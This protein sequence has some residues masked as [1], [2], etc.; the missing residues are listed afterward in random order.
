MDAAIGID[1][2][3]VEPVAA[4]FTA[5]DEPSA[6]L[7]CSADVCADIADKVM[8]DT[9]AFPGIA[10]LDAI[11]ATFLDDTVRDL[12][13]VK[14]RSGIGL[15]RAVP[16][17]KGFGGDVVKVAV[18]NVGVVLNPTS[19]DIGEEAADASAGSVRRIRVVYFEVIEFDLFDLSIDAHSA[20]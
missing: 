6:S 2:D 11:P 12:K 3:I 13:V 15:V 20:V 16:G 4:A 9:T 8:V 18:V 17:V 19:R 10:H 1:D 14:G 5:D 7:G